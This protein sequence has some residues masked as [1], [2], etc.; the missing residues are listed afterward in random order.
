MID[1]IVDLYLLMLHLLR[2]KMHM[3]HLEYRLTK[4]FDLVLFKCGTANQK[5][6]NME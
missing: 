2:D 3:V 5:I 6:L 4:L 1:L